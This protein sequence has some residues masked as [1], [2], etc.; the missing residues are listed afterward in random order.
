MKLMRAFV[1]LTVLAICSTAIQAQP[2]GAF[3]SLSPLTR[4]LGAIQTLSGQTGGTVTASDQTGYNVSRVICVYRQTA[5][6]SSPTVVFRLENKDGA[7]GVYYTVLSSTAQTATPTN[8][9][10]LTMGAGVAS[11]ANVASGFPVARNWRT[12]VQVSGASA[13][14]TG[15]VGCSVQ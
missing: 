13:T 9:V 8:T 15:T 10:V 11:S 7:S 5:S 3:Q 14:V 4:D 6:S 1:A 12:T 2:A